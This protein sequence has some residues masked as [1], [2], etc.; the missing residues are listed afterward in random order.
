M[1]RQGPAPEGGEPP[2]SSARSSYLTLLN[3]AVGAGVL[4]FPSAFRETGWA[5]GLILLLVVGLVE[6][7]TLYVLS[8]YAESTG[9]RTY[10]ALV[11]GA[12]W[13]GRGRA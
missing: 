1:S 9:A 8:R 10:T 13:G 5:G 7:F 3:A 4:S 2:C 6:A 11:R 12:G